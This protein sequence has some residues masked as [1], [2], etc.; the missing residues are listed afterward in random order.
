L[1]EEQFVDIVITIKR[2]SFEERSILLKF[3]KGENIALTLHFVQPQEYIIVFRGLKFEPDAGTCEA[4]ALIGQKGTLC[5][6]LKE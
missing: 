5:K 4:S 3:K 6:A 2:E 1:R